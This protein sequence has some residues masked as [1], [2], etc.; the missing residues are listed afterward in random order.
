[1]KS[2][3]EFSGLGFT[4]FAFRSSRLAKAFAASENIFIDFRG[5]QRL[6]FRQTEKELL[7]ALSLREMHYTFQKMVQYRYEPSGPDMAHW[8]IVLVPDDEHGTV[9]FL[10]RS[11]TQ[12]LTVVQA[13]K[14]AEELNEKL[15]N[16][17][18]AA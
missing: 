13:E 7:F 15:K 12:N 2:R 3:R 9:M 11:D 18:I 4:Y 17:G 14:K 1:M 8:C 10:Q 6:Y 16:K 5:Q